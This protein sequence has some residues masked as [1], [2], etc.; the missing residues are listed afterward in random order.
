M[1]E[2]RISETWYEQS[3]DL[4]EFDTVKSEVE[5][6]SIR[7][8]ELVREFVLKLVL[9]AGDCLVVERSIL[10]WPGASLAG[11]VGILSWLRPMIL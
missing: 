7:S 4:G 5:W 10:P 9:G 8:K 3:L 11:T 1:L 2:K 6:I